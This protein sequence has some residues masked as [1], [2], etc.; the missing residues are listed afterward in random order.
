MKQVVLL[1][2]I[3]ILLIVIIDVLSV[4]VVP[5]RKATGSS[6]IFA[7]IIAIKK[8]VDQD[9]MGGIHYKLFNFFSILSS[10]MYISSCITC[11]YVYKLENKV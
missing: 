2:I 6:K 3:V 7:V 4:N 5:L 11:L 1:V 10:N 8:I 9:M